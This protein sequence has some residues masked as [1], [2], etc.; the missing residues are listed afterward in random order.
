[1]RCHALLFLLLLSACRLC[2][3]QEMSPLACSDGCV[4]AM[5]MPVPMLV[6]VRACEVAPSAPAAEADAWLLLAALAVCTAGRLAT[7][8][9]R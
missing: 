1:M 9:R 8:R 4:A 7:S 5:P 2:G 6:P 3:A